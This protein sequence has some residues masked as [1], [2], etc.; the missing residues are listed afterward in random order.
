M[1][2]LSRRGVLGAAGVAVV[3]AMA[4]GASAQAAGKTVK[5]IGISCSPRKGKNSAVALSAALEAAKAVSPVV[6]VEMIELAGMKIPAEVAAG[7]AL[8][9]G[10]QD[11]FPTIE[12]K[13][14]D[15][16]LGGI[17]LATPVYFSSMSSQCKGLLERF[18]V[19][20]KNFD[21]SDKVGGVIATGA[22]RNGGQEMTIQSVHAILLSQDMIIVSEG[23]PHP[24]LGGILVAGPQN[25]V[26]QD[27]TGMATAKGVGRRVAEV[28]L[29]L[30]AAR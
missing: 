3:G 5:I 15:P 11:D 12:A 14:R 18:M 10:Q 7:I 26:T 2:A 17:I 28:A 20:R 16:N 24:R 9:P 29:K 19:F 1:A 4:R 6:Q 23:K 21:L 27:E 8:E 22:A 25:D 30:A 13:L